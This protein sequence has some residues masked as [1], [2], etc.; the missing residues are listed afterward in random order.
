MFDVPAH[1]TA[2]L[3]AK[4]TSG[5]TFDEI[6]A[7]LDK[8]EVWTTALFFGQ[9]RCDE[10]TAKK[11]V[12]LLSIGETFTYAWGDSPEK[13]TVSGESVVMGLAGK[14]AG[15]LG[16]EGMSVR[17]GTWDGPPKVSTALRAQ[18]GDS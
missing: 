2:L 10:A 18:L 16:V 5:K 11:I 1:S 14:G 6:A 4:A 17:G 8:P 13:K 12:E 15:S 9:N 3:A 7:A